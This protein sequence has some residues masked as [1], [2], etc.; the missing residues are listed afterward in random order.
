ML[1]R[2][3]TVQ[4]RERGRKSY[5]AVLVVMQ[6]GPKSLAREIYLDPPTTLQRPCR[7]SSW[8]LVLYRVLAGSR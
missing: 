4:R 7:S 1:P 5:D 8:V 2:V 3:S 6:Q